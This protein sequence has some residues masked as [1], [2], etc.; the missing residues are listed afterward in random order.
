MVGLRRST[1]PQAIWRCYENGGRPVACRG[2][3]RSGD[4]NGREGG[5]ALSTRPAQH[6]QI[7]AV[8]LGFEKIIPKIKLRVFACAILP[9][10]VHLVIDR[11]PDPVE[12]IIGYLKRAATRELNR[13]G[14]NPLADYRNESG[15]V[16]S[17]WVRGGW[18]RYL[19]TAD[20]IAGAV[21]YANRN[22]VQARMLPQDWPFVSKYF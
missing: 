3:A 7:E 16:P 2:A 1:A 13:M 4:S 21:E 22:L 6:R 15:E 11:H 12:E 9:D 14:L 20:E 18:N 17:I 10:H 5:A 8:G 19:N